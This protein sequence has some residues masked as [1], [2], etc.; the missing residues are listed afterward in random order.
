[1]KLECQ[2]NDRNLLPQSLHFQRFFRLKS[3]T[4]NLPHHPLQLTPH[5]PKLS[6]DCQ[7]QAANK[8]SPLP[9]DDRPPFKR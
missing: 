7:M 6:V 1:M 5:K 9:S 4:R 2:Q 8:P 3:F